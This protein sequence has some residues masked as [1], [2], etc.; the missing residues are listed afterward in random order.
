MRFLA[1]LTPFAAATPFSEWL[2]KESLMTPITK[3]STPCQALDMPK[4]WADQNPFAIMIELASGAKQTLVEFESWGELSGS[5]CGDVGLALSKMGDAITT[6]NA[7]MVGPLI[8]EAKSLRESDEWVQSGRL[9]KELV[10]VSDP[11]SV[12][13]EFL[14]VTRVPLT[15]EEIEKKRALKLTKS[16][17]RW[18]PVGED[19]WMTVS[20]GYALDV[21]LRGSDFAVFLNL[22]DS[23]GE[24]TCGDLM[25]AVI[26]VGPA[27]WT[28]FPKNI[29][30]MRT[31]MEDPSAL[32]T[33]EGRN[34]NKGGNPSFW[35]YPHSMGVACTGVGATVFEPVPGAE[36]T[37][38]RSEGDV[39]SVCGLMLDQKDM[40]RVALKK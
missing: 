9:K 29:A 14:W 4:V 31:M 10:D 28:G 38:L 25:D 27:L 30:G 1:V 2:L 40:I 26:S 21:F 13:L 12:D 6:E 34:Y 33:G 19:I 32:N 8:V 23:K 7:S 35:A 24:M 39:V 16:T 36:P 20:S 17:C 11:E 5:L 18:L 22:D 15:E 37:L 3:T